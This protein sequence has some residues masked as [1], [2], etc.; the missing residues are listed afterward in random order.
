MQAIILA[1]G[2]GTRLKPLT[3]NIPKPLLPISGERTLLDAVLES[4][5]PAVEEVLIIVGYLEEKIRARYGSEFL[6]KKITYVFQK[7]RN[8]TAGAVFLCRDKI[9]G[10][11]L[12]LSGDDF[13]ASKNIAELAGRS[14]A[15]LVDKREGQATGG[16][17]TVNAA[18]NL[19]EIKEYPS[20]KEENYLL[21]A[22]AYKLDQRIFNYAPVLIS[23]GLQELGL[24]QTISLLAADYPVEVV[25]ASVFFQANTLEGLE[26][27]R[28]FLKQ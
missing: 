13:Y 9:K 21:C 17:V 24:P 18:G 25:R 16:A 20:L 4:L 19:L 2:E 7:E 27:I 26:E 22:G 1:A 15:V 5:P 3:D 6:G 12:V 8:G 11:F 10:E 28:N 14:L 23:E